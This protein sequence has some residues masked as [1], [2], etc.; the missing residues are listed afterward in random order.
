VS[1]R[2]A[3]KLVAGREVRERFR[4][5]GFR[6]STAVMLLAVLGIVALAAHRSGGGPKRAT[7]AVAGPAAAAVANAARDLQGAFDLRLELA[8]TAD[9]ESARDEV[10][11]GRADAAPVG[12][13]LVVADDAPDGL[14][15]LLQEAARR[16]RTV[17]ALERAG[18][19]AAQ[20]R[21]AL[22]VSPPVV[23]VVGR[24]EDGAAALAFL[25]TLLLYV[26]LFTF[27]Y[28]VAS[29]VV[30]E[31]SSRVIE[32]VLS[33]IRPVTLLAGKVIGIGLLGLAQLVA[34]AGVGFGAALLLDQVELPDAA[35][36]AIALSIVY[37]VLGYAFYACLFAAAGAIV[38]RQEDL[39]S[40]TAPIGLVLVV[41]YFVSIP[42]A[43]SPDSTLAR[44]ATLVPA[45]APLSVPARAAQGALPAWELALSLGVMAAGTVLVLLLATR[46]Y[47]RSVLRLGAPLKLRQALRLAAR[48][49]EALTPS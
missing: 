9:P 37:F 15:A 33:A 11:A 38:A 34:I 26:G 17:D 25:V 6:A 49:E 36:S 21:A 41:S 42:V 39:Q 30:E 28:Y 18:V 40:T 44:V 13:S 7:V 45:T 16:V 43:D 8:R 20:A 46:I 32:V 14:A 4:S 29:G 31:K 23:R 3:V 24:D 19:P 2:R 10:A 5:R 27:G 22:A 47:E 1:K 35:P 48:S 12:D